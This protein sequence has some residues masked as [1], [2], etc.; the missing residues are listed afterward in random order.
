[1]SNNYDEYDDYYEEYDDQEDDSS[2]D[3]GSANDRDGLIA[4]VRNDGTEAKDKGGDSGRTRKIIFGLLFVFVILP[5]LCVAC[6]F[7]L[8]GGAIVAAL[9]GGEGDVEISTILE[10]EP[11]TATPI[12]TLMATAAVIILPTETPSPTPTPTVAPASATFVSP[13]NGAR[14]NLG[15]SVELVVQ[16]YDPNGITSVNIDGSRVSPQTF[17]GETA[18]E[19]RQRWAPE[20]TGV[21]SLSVIMRN[22]LGESKTLEGINVIVVDES[23]AAQNAGTFNQLSNNVSAL[24]GLPLLEAVSPNVLNREGLKNYL[25]NTAVYN[26]DDIAQD[27]LVLRAFDFVGTQTDSEIY[28]RTIEYLQDNV[29]GFYDPVAQILGLVSTDESVDLYEQYVFVHELMHALQDQHFGLDQLTST[30]GL[31]DDQALALRAVVEG[32]AMLLQEKYLEQGYF[33]A[34]QQ[35][36]IFNLGQMRAGNRAGNGLPP[37][38]ASVFWFPYEA[39]NLFVTQAYEAGGGWQGVND[40]WANPPLSTEQI[41]HPERYAAGDVPQDVTLP[42]LAGELGA[43]WQLVAQRTLGEFFLRE[44]LAQQLDE[45]AVDTAVTGWGGDQYAVFANPNTN[46]LVL[47]F[48]TAWDTPEDSAEFGAAYEQYASRAFG[49]TVTEPAEGVRCHTAVVE[50]LCFTAVGDEW[51]I[52]RAPDENTAVALLNTAR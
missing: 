6:P 45:G 23:F 38:L 10:D 26:R 8:G 15:E 24:R 36:E 3:A 32:E 9:L 30:T 34:Q 5:M 29:A 31:Y 41:I 52:V 48:R 20:N 21:Q 22:R 50:V 16:L 42:E 19:F 44:Y 37:I 33:N 12:A 7:L 1:M 13:A 27:L 17:G 39:G 28:D 2:I 18:V 46:Q 4:D 35:A 47:V 43:G 25:R 51:L 49:S 11:A 40:V 14:I